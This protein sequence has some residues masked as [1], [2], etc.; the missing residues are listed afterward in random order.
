[1]AELKSLREIPKKEPVKNQEVENKP[2][3]TVEKVAEKQIEKQTE[4]FSL[5]RKI[6]GDL[7]FELEFSTGKLVVS[8]SKCSQL[9]SE[10]KKMNAEQKETFLMQAAIF[11]ANPFSVPAEIYPVPFKN[12]DN[13]ITYAPVINYKKYID[14]GASNPRFDG[15]RS[16][17]VVETTD[18]EIKNRN[19][20]VFGS[21]ETLIGGWCE[22]YVK[23][24]KEP[25]FRSVNLNEFEQRDGNGVLTKFWDSKKG[26]PA[27]MIEKVACKIA[28]EIAMKMP[29]TFIEEELPAL[30]IEHEELA[31][32]KAIAANNDE[33]FNK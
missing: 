29:K 23:G 26:K 8:E 30:D 31:E 9:I 3:K 14:F 4:G 19:G 27:L 11:G 13:T 10:F 18:S 21:K 22:V 20:Q 15:M 2:E 1:M 17:V 6:N 25:I 28:F 12:K 7:Y 33:F 32:Q 16:G 24:I 5:L